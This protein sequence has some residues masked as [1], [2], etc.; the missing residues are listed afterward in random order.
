MNTPVLEYSTAT[1]SSLSN[2]SI[3]IM[4]HLN[5]NSADFQQQYM[6]ALLNYRKVR[7]LES[8]TSYDEFV[9]RVHPLDRA[10]GENGAAEVMEEV[11]RPELDG[12]SEVE[13]ATA[14]QVSLSF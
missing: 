5:D 8:V 4:Q 10:N 11:E 3:N 12:N 2:P 9:P 1:Q 7:S 14:L 13:N 6:D